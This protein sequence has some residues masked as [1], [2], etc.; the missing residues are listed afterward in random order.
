MESKMCSIVISSILA[1]AV[2]AGIQSSFLDA[3]A[4]EDD[5][6]DMELGG[7]PELGGDT[8]MTESDLGGND[9][10]ITISDLENDTGT[11]NSQMGHE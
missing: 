11:T 1:F 2:I 5:N 7:D 6:R 4:Q 8:G 3:L 10:G 9:T